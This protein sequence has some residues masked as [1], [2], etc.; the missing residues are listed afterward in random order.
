MSSLQLLVTRT[1]DRRTAMY[2]MNVFECIYHDDD[3]L[4]KRWDGCWIQK[5]SMPGHAE[6]LIKGR[7]SMYTVI[8]GRCSSGNYLCIPE[9]RISCPLSFLSDKFWNYEQL[10]SLL[11]T[12]DAVTVTTALADFEIHKQKI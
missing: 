4:P 10:S 8:L 6:L 2:D 1:W 3:G 5:A 12:V 9:Q 7:G 11:G